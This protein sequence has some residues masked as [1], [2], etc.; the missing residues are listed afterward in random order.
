MQKILT[1]GDKYGSSILSPLSSYYLLSSLPPFRSL[2]SL[3][4]VIICL[5]LVV[6][7]TGDCL[8]VIVLLVIF[9][10]SLALPLF[11]AF[12]KQTDSLALFLL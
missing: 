11:L 3:L 4:H 6:E 10:S 9:F 8:V 2:F 5:N 1:G 12:V 7:S